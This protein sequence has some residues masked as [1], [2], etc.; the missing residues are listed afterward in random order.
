MSDQ[1]ILGTMPVSR[2]VFHMSWP[3]ML[4]MLT[5]AIYNLVDSIYVAQLSDAAFLALS[6]AFPVQ[7]LLTACCVGI[8]VGFSALLGKR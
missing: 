2:L 1:N 5:Q 7:N 6:Y 3:I 4:S 8:G